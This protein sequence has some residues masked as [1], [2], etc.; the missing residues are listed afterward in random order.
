MGERA[1]SMSDPRASGDAGSAE[2]SDPAVIEAEIEATRQEMS[3]TIE[4]IEERLAPEQLAEQAKEV[5]HHAIDEAQGAVRD[6][7]GQATMAAREATMG[8]AEQVTVQTRD[9]AQRV[10]GDLWTTMKHNPV[11]VAFAAGGIGWMWTR[12]SRS[13][14]SSRHADY[15]AS[16]IESRQQDQSG[17][18]PP[19]PRLLAGRGRR[20][21]KSRRWRR[22]VA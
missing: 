20:R 10:K 6:L 16:G 4:A 9:T 13:S 5:A 17:G 8:K 21:E 3:E 1:G 22:D 12:R 14:G 2:E 18:Q 15:G 19:G 11:L 7:A